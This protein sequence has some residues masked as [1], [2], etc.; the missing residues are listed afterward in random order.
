M[1]FPLKKNDIKIF[2]QKLTI[3]HKITYN[4]FKNN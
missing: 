4:N 1:H 3:R 2:L